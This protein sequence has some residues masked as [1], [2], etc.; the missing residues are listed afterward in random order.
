MALSNN[1][2]CWNGLVTPDASASVGFLTDL[3]GWT[4]EDVDMGDGPMTMLSNDGHAFAHIRKPEEGEPAWWNNF[5]RVE[6]VDA[7]VETLHSRGGAVVVPPTDIPPGRFATVKMPSGAL[8]SVYRESGD[9]ADRP[10]GRGHVHW[11]DLHSTDLD[12]DLVALEALGLDKDTMDTPNGPYHVLS[13]STATR[14]GAMKG[15][16]EDAPS[17]WLAWIEVE[18]TDG[19]VKDIE[20]K[21]GSILAPAWDGPGV[22]RMAI[23]RGPAGI[24]FGV[25]QPAAA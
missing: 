14:A 22:G 16:N 24:V 6:N 4:H 15:A 10:V 23:A 11:V 8:F 2:F 20:A 21:G 25:I 17:M 18:S 19:I 7:A 12:A 9:D 3:F 5:L 1:T 13:P